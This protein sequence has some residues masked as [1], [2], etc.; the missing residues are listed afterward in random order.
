MI[1]RERRAK[2]VGG[3]IKNVL[4]LRFVNELSQFSTMTARRT[5][6]AVQIGLNSPTVR[7]VKGLRN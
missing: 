4:E 1:R 6:G 3:L 7:L 5:D 2:R